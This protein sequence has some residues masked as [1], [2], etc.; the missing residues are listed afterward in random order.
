M[1]N[2]FNVPAL[3]V[4]FRETLEAAVVISIMISIMERLGQRRLKRQG[5]H[6]SIYA[7]AN[8]EILLPGVASVV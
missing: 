5:T 4:M 3:L 7:A 2:L 1:V 6:V 8:L